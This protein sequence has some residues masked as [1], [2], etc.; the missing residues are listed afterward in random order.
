MIN[1]LIDKSH[2]V[3]TWLSSRANRLRLRGARVEVV[4][5]VVT[6]S[7]VTSLLLVESAYAST[8][9]PPQEGVNLGETFQDA[10]YRCVQDEC[11]INIPSEL[12]ERRKL[13]YLRHIE[14]LG[15]LDL[16]AE[17]SGE[18]LVADNAADTPLGSIK[19][20]RKAYWAALAI[21]KDASDMVPEP[22]GREIVNAG[23]FDFDKAS[24][25]IQSTNRPEKATLLLKGVKL[26]ERH[27]R[28]S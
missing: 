1:Y 7:P 4:A 9:M 8:W 21:I 14:Y 5:F 12:G 15:M 6:R 27:L 2:L 23:W 3:A 24:D 10:F 25:L 19:L 22:D 11:G 17:R 20:K 13:F 26:C 16:P 18:R 28:G